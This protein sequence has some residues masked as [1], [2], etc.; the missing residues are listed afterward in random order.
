MGPLSLFR[1]KFFLNENLGKQRLLLLRMANKRFQHTGM[2]LAV[3]T[4]TRPLRDVHSGEL[5]CTRI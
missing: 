5:H 2:Y 4:S 1:G 3:Y